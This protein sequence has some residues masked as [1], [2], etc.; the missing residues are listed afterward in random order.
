MRKLG[1]LRN[2]W[3]HMLGFHNLLS[4]P[5]IEFYSVYELFIEKEPILGFWLQIS[6]TLRKIAKWKLM[7]VF[8]KLLYYEQG[9]TQGQSLS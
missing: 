1:D 6:I 9:V 3:V 2:M 7:F 5:S 8:S 4:R